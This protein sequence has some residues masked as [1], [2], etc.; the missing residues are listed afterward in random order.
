MEYRVAAPAHTPAAILG[1]P[2]TSVPNRRL[3]MKNKEEKAQNTIIKRVYEK[4]VLI[5]I[6]TEE[7]R[8]KRYPARYE[9]A[10]GGGDYA[11]S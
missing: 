11:P 2:P 7:S 1:Q 10:P 8:G 9:N 6:S 4:P 3:E 5:V